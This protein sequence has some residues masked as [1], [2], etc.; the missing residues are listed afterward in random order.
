RISSDWKW[1]NKTFTWAVTVPPNTTATVYMPE[2]AASLTESGK[3]LA[4]ANG[5]RFLRTEKG[6]AVYELQSGDYLLMAK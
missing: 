5:V 6:R 2:N 3:P 1:D 4:K